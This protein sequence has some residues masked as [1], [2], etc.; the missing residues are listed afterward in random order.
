[1]VPKD[2]GKVQRLVFG[3]FTVRPWSRQP[4]RQ[5]KARG[6]T[7]VAKHHHISDFNPGVGG[8]IKKGQ[9]VVLR[10][11][12]VRGVEQ[13]VVDSYFDKNPSP[14]LYEPDLSGP[15]TTRHHP[16]SV[17]PHH[18]A[19]ETEGQDPVLVHEP[20]QD[21]STT[22]STPAA[23]RTRGH[24]EP[25]RRGDDPA[26]G[27]G[28]KRAGCCSRAARSRPDAVREGYQPSVTTHDRETI[29]GTRSTRSP[30]GERQGLRR[31]TAGYSRSAGI[32]R[33]AASA[34]P[35]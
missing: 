9:A 16:Q 6:M 25:V 29:Q 31:S 22:A 17:V 18:V 8:P 14:Y 35:T 19:G 20:E 28:R 23:R 11:V 4:D 34:A 21:A 24:Q 30:I 13:T 32:R 10:R 15:A 5:L 3:D 33:S 27:R 12:A 2:G 26:N 7:N 1:M